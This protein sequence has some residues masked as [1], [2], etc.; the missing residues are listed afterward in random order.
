MAKGLLQTIYRPKIY[1]KKIGLI[2]EEL[3]P[4]NARQQ[5]LFHPNAEDQLTHSAQL[6]SMLDRIHS[7]FGRG[8][9]RLAAGK[10]RAEMRASCV[11]LRL[12]R[13]IDSSFVNE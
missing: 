10:I 8:T 5:D 4:A 6:M 12:L 7:R 3:Q 1:Y 11:V 2:L 9:L 13:C